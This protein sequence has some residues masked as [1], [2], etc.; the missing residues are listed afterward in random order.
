MIALLAGSQL[1]D[2]CNETSH[3]HMDP[4]LEQ[5][6]EGQR[7]AVEHRAGP[8]LVV[9]GPGSGKTRV[10]THRIAHLIAGGVEPDS[11]LAIT[12]T[13]KAAN[14][15]LQRTLGLLP[16]SVVDGRRGPRISTFHSFCARL[17][18]REIYH[19][20]P[21]QVDYTIYDT[22]DQR[23]LMEEVLERLNFD[24]STFPP[25]TCLS[26]ISSWKNQL[27]SSEEAFD[28]AE[29]HRT[30]QMA[31]IFKV[32]QE[33]LMERNALDFD[34][35]LLLTLQLLRESEQVRNRRRRLHGYLLVDEFQD[36]NRPQ[37]LIVRLLAQEHHNLC[38]TGDPD[39][40]IYSWRGASPENFDLFREDFPEFRAV[41]LEQ[42]YRSTPQ[43]LSVASRLTG[44]ELGNRTLFTHN[45]PGDKVCVR[46]LQDERSEA[47]AIVEQAVAWQSQG[48]PLREI[49]VLYRVNSLSRSIEEELVRSQVPYIIVGGTAFYQRKEIKDVLCYL[50]AAT[51]P[52]D[53]LAVRRI[54]NTPNRGIGKV[55]LERFEDLARE[56]GLSLGEALENP[57]ILGKIPARAR[58]ALTDL[59]NILE[60]LESAKAQPLH[61]QI[62][63]AIQASGY[64]QFLE[65]TE[66]ESWHD[67]AQNLE[68][69]ANA[70]AETEELLRAARG[71]HDQPLDP[72]VIFLERVALVTDVDHWRER[73]DR[74][75]LMTLHSAKGL[76]F[77]RVIIAGVEETLLPHSRYE[78]ESSVDEE[79]RLLYVGITRARQSI[80]LLHT[81]W[82][83][84]FRDPEPRLPSQFLSQLENEEVVVFEDHAQPVPHRSYAPVAPGNSIEE[85]PYD[86]ELHPGVWLEHDLFG[87][88]IITSTSGFGNTKRITVLFEE[89]TFGEK[90]LVASY[91]PLRIISGP[92]S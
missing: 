51:F 4:D 80:L 83:R 69:L 37:Y 31:R 43:I 71:H 29:S 22:L 54:I 34:D 70:A 30:R 44:T 23:G 81:A 85:D 27:V 87:R 40:S 56:Q 64:L 45:A 48:T 2:H 76:E 46:R 16:G 59:H 35:L 61:S 17:L 19:L 63:L 21:Y 6:N 5:L 28:Q 49:A 36:T 62:E 60:Q 72:L 12:F 86:D 77:D 53:E 55:T 84:R 18:R 78:E 26:R 68:E 33:L 15:M 11:I 10:M 90:Q 7:V 41:H 14:E 32:F 8:L 39:Q 67:R 3:L 91:A 50:R 89:K 66:P 13:N 74:V 88:G 25:R 92:G 79:R 73:D 24:R 65:R 1:M 47:R 9:A 58:K 20:P 42:N 52:R 57:T 82:R 38:I 75:A